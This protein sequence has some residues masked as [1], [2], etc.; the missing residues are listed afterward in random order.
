MILQLPGRFANDRPC[1]DHRP[2]PSARGRPAARAPLETPGKADSSEE[3]VRFFV[4]PGTESPVDLNIV[5]EQV[6][7]AAVARD[8][9]GGSFAFPLKNP[10][11][12]GRRNINC[13]D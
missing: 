10:S 12:Q 3:I 2:G 13:P 5:V 4:Q 8:G 1:D 9:L 6:G 7:K 11:V